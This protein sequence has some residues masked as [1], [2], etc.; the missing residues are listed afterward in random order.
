[1]TSRGG[2]PAALAVLAALAAAPALGA[3]GD[4]Q[5]G[6]RQSAADGGAG[7]N[8]WSAG[9]ALSANGRFLAFMS[10]ANNLDVEDGF[11]SIYVY[12]FRKRVV[13]NVSR[14]S[15]FGPPSD[16]DDVDPQVSANGRFVA[17]ETDATNLGGPTQDSDNIY[18]Y[19]RKLDQ[20]ELVSRQS[21]SVGGQGADGESSN[22]T[23]SASGRYVA[24]TSRAANLGGP[25]NNGPFEA[26]VYVYDRKQDRVFLGS[27]RSN[28]GKG[29]NEASY[30]PVLAPSA[31]I[32]V[33]SSQS[34]NL[35]GPVNN[36]Q[37][38]SNV[39]AYNWRAKTTELVSRRSNRGKGANASA[40]VA[41]VSGKA[42]HVLFTTEAGNLG[43]PI[44]NV[45]DGA[46]IAYLHDRKTGRTTLVSRRANDGPAANGFVGL[47]VISDSGR[48]IAYDTSATNLGGPT[49]A[50][51]NVYVY[52]RK[53]KRLKL[54]SRGT[55]GGPGAD[56]SS[57]APAIA[58][59]RPFVIFTTA[60]D[61]IDPPGQP[62][63]HGNFPPATSVYRFQFAR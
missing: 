11:R 62:A 8:S 29:G 13:E 53:T 57:Y 27:R 35:G 18:V 36:D 17:F 46:S 40:N 37:F 33:F 2:I 32:V 45:P 61:N 1:L 48:H 3:N 20:V 39:Y 24:F 30:D 50:A 6:S 16:G 7:A 55:R 54:A 59:A 26:N 25:I 60:A 58:G 42:R 21:A 47:P 28:N 41:D 52:D 14:A 15:N 4:L 49:Q 44:K 56:E 38:E 23:I 9:G 10:E 31:P 19:D 51:G 63:Y 34:R 43:G 5:L 12:D 22:P